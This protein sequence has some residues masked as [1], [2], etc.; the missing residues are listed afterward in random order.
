[1]IALDTN[2]LVY[3]HRVHVAEHERARDALE[4]VANDPRP[5]ALPWPVAHEFVRVVTAARDAPAPLG[6]ALAA[7]SALLSTPGCRPIAEAGGYWDRLEQL[8][9]TGK[10]LRS[11][12]YDARIAAICLQHGVRELWTSDRDFGRFPELRVVNPLVG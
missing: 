7:V 6:E 5:W 8:A 12:I 10:A 3:A 9:V 2:I 4:L 11:R 1:V